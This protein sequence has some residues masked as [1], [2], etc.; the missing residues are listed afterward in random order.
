M[1]NQLP[2]TVEAS[3]RG[4]PKQV[5]LPSGTKL[6]RIV[7]PG[8]NNNLGEYWFSEPTFK[9]ILDQMKKQNHSF[10]TVARPRL[11]VQKAWNLSMSH[12]VIF[13]LSVEMAAWIGPVR[14]QPHSSRLPNVLFMGNLEQIYI[15]NLAKDNRSMDS[16]YGC[17]QFYG[18]PF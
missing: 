5:T 6:Y 9:A 10:E 13:K 18:S 1:P 12:I 16:K 2:A 14:F 11:A 4:I 3:F 8:Q 7:T 17:I 15:P